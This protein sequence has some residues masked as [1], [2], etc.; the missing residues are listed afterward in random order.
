MGIILW[1]FL[2]KILLGVIFSIGKYFGNRL[3]SSLQ[4]SKKCQDE[5]NV[6]V[7]GWIFL[8]GGCDRKCDELISEGEVVSLFF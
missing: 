3:S 4:M 6:Q 8:G 1:V 2:W 7:Q 5:C